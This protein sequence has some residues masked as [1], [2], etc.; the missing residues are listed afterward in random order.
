MRPSLIALQKATKTRLRNN[1]SEEVSTDPP[2]PGIE[3]G[4]D[5]EGGVRETTS[6]VHTDAQQTI[7][8]RAYTELK[9]KQIG[10]DVAE[11][12]TDRDDKLS[13][14]APFNLLR[15]ELVDIDMQRNRRTE[16][17]DIFTDLIIVQHRI[18]RL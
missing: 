14:S 18:S 1:L 6:S 15:S 12:L 4:D 17:K 2:I 5:N 7:R 8:A 13:L 16:G 3:I 11:E 9:A 10:R